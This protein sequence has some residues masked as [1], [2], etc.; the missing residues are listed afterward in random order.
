[1]SWIMERMLKS[2]QSPAIAD[3]EDYLFT[4]WR[5]FEETVRKMK[6]GY[7]EEYGKERLGSL[8]ARIKFHADLADSVAALR[9][10]AGK[11]RRT[12]LEVLG[13]IE[14]TMVRSLTDLTSRGW[15][16]NGAAIQNFM[17]GG[18]Q[19]GNFKD[20]LASLYGT[21]FGTDAD[22]SP[23]DPGLPATMREV[24]RLLAK[25][26]TQDENDVRKLT[27]LPLVEVDAEGNL[28]DRSL[29]K[30]AG[31][32]DETTIRY[33]ASLE[34]RANSQETIRDKAHTEIGTALDEVRS[35]RGQ[36]EG[37]P[38]GADASG[39]L[40][41]ARGKWETA[42][43]GIAADLTG[44]SYDTILER[45]AEVEGQDAAIKRME[46]FAD[47]MAQRVFG[48]SAG[49]REQ[50]A[51]IVMNPDFREW[52]IANGY[53]DLGQGKW[54]ASGR[55]IGYT[56]GK[57]DA[58]A[59]LLANWQVRHPHPWKRPVTDRLVEVTVMEPDAEIAKL[60]DPITG[61]VAY[62]TVGGKQEWLSVEDA[63]ARKDARL[64][65]A[66]VAIS[67][68]GRIFLMGG[69]KTRERVDGKWVEVTATPPGLEWAPLMAGETAPGGVPRL[70]SVDEAM[71]ANLDD[72]PMLETPAEVAL[73]DVKEGEVPEVGVRTVRGQV[74]RPRVTPKG[75]EKGLSVVSADVPGGYELFGP[76]AHIEVKEV[77]KVPG[78]RGRGEPRVGLGVAVGRAQARRATRRVE[79]AEAEAAKV[80]PEAAKVAPEAAPPPSPPPPPLPPSP[81]PPTPPSPPAPPPTPISTVKPPEP[82]IAT[83]PPP[84]RRPPPPP[85][86]PSKKEEG[87]LPKPEE[88]LTKAERKTVELRE[89][90]QQ[91]WRTREAGIFAPETQAKAEAA[92][93]PPPGPVGKALGASAATAPP[94]AMRGL[95][96]EVLPPSPPSPPPKLAKGEP[97]APPSRKEAAQPP[98]VFRG[99][100]KPEGVIQARPPA[101]T[102]PTARDDAAAKKRQ[103]A[104]SLRSLT[105][106][107]LQEL[108][109]LGVAAAMAPAGME[110]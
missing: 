108:K 31:V 64:A 17:V 98:G 19:H 54:D 44:D 46:K 8:N 4:T 83:V 10:S 62:V 79:A 91:G 84:E 41:R 15:Q 40:Q 109:K 32:A 82:I 38:E 92:A 43:A 53:A 22:L 2:A 29:L 9:E 61:K 110:D 16:M 72:V 94:T 49:A 77:G 1:M 107:E 20:G 90:L 78:R 68:D 12:Q 7:S 99:G 75:A 24:K 67:G 81:P 25:S 97:K 58:S 30:R 39:L 55:F 66:E 76:D 5:S 93:A 47:Q 36:V 106:D 26:L 51:R 70:M 80:A 101:A 85:L 73:F 88:M 37:L 57:D 33:A 23:T 48:E 74:A 69:G 50:A 3:P 59:M 42:S 21:Y 52:A 27:D 104:E 34:D 45:Y 87:E 14:T 63:K 95:P 18:A 6:E 28:T 105:P 100:P 13:R 102:V 11:D 65:A 103:L 56:E 96:A 35:L 71:A 89:R 86:P 60:A